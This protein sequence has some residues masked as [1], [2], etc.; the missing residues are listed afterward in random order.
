[1]RLLLIFLSIILISCSPTPSY[2]NTQLVKLPNHTNAWQ[3]QE[4]NSWPSTDNVSRALQIFYKHWK[5]E[6]GDKDD[7]VFL[8]LNSIMIE[9][10]DEKSQR[11]LGYSVDGN[12]N[13][14]TF[15]GVAISPS[16]IRIWKNRYNR[17]ASTA[18]IHELVHIAL[19]NTGSSQGDPD[20]EGNLYEG[21]TFKHTEF[22]NNLNK[23][24]ANI[25]I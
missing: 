13:S 16:Y 25:D 22:I 12:I 6:F 4:T 7:K 17:I 8:A 18:L 23:I 2:L 20:H 14:G 5:Q 10:T 21:W 24:S 9:W 11:A 1:M 3:I 15:R 19:W